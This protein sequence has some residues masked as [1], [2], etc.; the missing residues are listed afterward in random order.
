MNDSLDIESTLEKIK[1]AKKERKKRQPVV[2]DEKNRRKS[3]LSISC[4]LIFRRIQGLTPEISIEEAMMEADTQDQEPSAV[5]T[6]PKP[7]KSVYV[8]FDLT[9]MEE[10]I[11]VDGSYHG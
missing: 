9:G 11:H 10:P 8:D 7:I 3:R 5:V 4:L 6:L 2:V 1:P